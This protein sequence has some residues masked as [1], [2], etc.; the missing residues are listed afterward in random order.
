DPRRF[1]HHRVVAEPRVALR[2][3]DRSV[4]ANEPRERLPKGTTSPTRI[5]TPAQPGPQRQ[6]AHEAAAG[7]ATPAAGPPPRPSA[8]PGDV[9]VTS[10]YP[11]AETASA[12]PAT[13]GQ[14]PRPRLSRAPSSCAP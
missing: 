1:P 10:A 5:L 12:A 7:P 4:P 6:P 14:P 3:L 2:G 13:A 8:D 11:G 9:P